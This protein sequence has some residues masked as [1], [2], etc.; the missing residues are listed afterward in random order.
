MILR[1]FETSISSNQNLTFNYISKTFSENNINLNEINI[2]ENLHITT[3]KKY[4]NLGLLF[5]DPNPFSFKLAVYQSREKASCC[6]RS[7]CKS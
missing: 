2:K 6:K 4:T 3:N 5:S 7:W 1:N